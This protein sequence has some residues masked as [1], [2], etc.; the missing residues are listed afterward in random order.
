MALFETSSGGKGDTQERA[1]RR[2]PRR[3]ERVSAESRLC[4]HQGRRAPGQAGPCEARAVLLLKSRLEPFG[5]SSDSASLS[6]GRWWAVGLLG[7]GG[8]AGWMEPPCPGAVYLRRKATLLLRR[9]AG[10]GKASC[11]WAWRWRLAI[12][13]S[14]MLPLAALWSGPAALGFFLGPLVWVRS[15]AI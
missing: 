6:D 13:G 11:S 7:R 3:R 4:S 14:R 5:E 12:L 9:T 8:R 1:D 2:W 15:I 10:E